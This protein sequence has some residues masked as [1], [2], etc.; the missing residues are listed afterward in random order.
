MVAS[1]F[2]AFA[3]PTSPPESEAVKAARGGA[4]SASQ[5]KAEA[6]DNDEEMS[7]FYDD[8]EGGEEEDAESDPDD[9]PPY[10]FPEM[11]ERIEEPKIPEA[12]NSSSHRREHARLVRRMDSVDIATCPEMARLWNGDRKDRNALLKKWVESGENVDLCESSLTVEKSSAGRSGEE[13]RT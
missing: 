2:P 1:H 5:P 3:N 13:P 9:G 8:E 6:V 11:P 7:G 4:P 10:P 12:I